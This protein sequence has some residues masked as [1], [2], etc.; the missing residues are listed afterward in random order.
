M[1]N[2]EYTIPLGR[3]PRSTEQRG[4]QPGSY[5]GKVIIP[6]TTSAESSSTKK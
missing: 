5:T 3:Q 1:N 4:F 6:K 2:K